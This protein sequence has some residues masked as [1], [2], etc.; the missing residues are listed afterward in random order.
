MN[1]NIWKKIRKEKTPIIWISIPPH[2]Q[3]K[4]KYDKLIDI[5]YDISLY[6]DSWTL[7]WNIDSETLIQCAPGAL[8]M[9]S[10]PGKIVDIFLIRSVVRDKV[11]LSQI[12]GTML[13]SQF[14]NCPEINFSKP[15]AID[16]RNMH[17]SSI[18]KKVKEW[19]KI[20]FEENEK[21]K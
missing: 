10:Q 20:F 4:E 21:L 16:V 14:G 18:S 3:K 2:S 11:K 5:T 15:L 12:C 1:K 13:W 17:H 19:A 6:G 8:F 7:G 9:F